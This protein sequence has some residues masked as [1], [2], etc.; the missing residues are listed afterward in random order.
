[1]FMFNLGIYHSR[2][3]YLAQQHKAGPINCMSCT[4]AIS[5]W[6]AVCRP[7]APR[8]TERAATE[9]RLR[10][11]IVNSYKWRFLRIRPF[12]PLQILDL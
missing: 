3:N 12:P 11:S 8:R 7:P 1:M 2:T 6:M 5:S 4:K 9:D 10:Y